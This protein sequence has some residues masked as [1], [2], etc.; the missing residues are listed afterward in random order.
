MKQQK[1]TSEEYHNWYKDTYK[2]ISNINHESH[3]KAVVRGGEV[4][5]IPVDKDGNEVSEK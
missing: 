4:C 2:F 3:Y 1:L 5:V